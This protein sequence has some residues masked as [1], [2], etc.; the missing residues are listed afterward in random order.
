MNL[1]EIA[2]IV[3]VII[4]IVYHLKNAL[5]SWRSCRRMERAI[6]EKGSDPIVGKLGWQ[7]LMLKDP[8]IILNESDLPE[9]KSCKS[10]FIN[11]W[12][13]SMRSHRITIKIAL[14]GLF[15]SIVLCIGQ[16]II[17]AIK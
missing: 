17:S 11:K 14:V 10:D 9:I 6:R 15:V 16:V 3:T 7:L 1:S 5:P 2:L 13:T 12:K 4:C 8:N